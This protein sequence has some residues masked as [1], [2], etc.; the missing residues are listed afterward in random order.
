MVGRAKRTRSRLSETGKLSIEV[1][2]RSFAHNGYVF[3]LRRP[4]RQEHF[5]DVLYRTGE[6]NFPKL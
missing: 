5:G 1:F 2:P 3:D 6:K 4:S